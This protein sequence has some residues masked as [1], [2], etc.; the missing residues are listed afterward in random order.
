MWQLPCPFMAYLLES[1]PQVTQYTKFIDQNTHKS[2]VEVW[3]LFIFNFLL[4]FYCFFFLVQ[5][6]SGN[7]NLGKPTLAM[8][9]RTI[10]SF[11]IK[12]SKISTIIYFNF[13]FSIS[14][15]HLYMC[16]FGIYLLRHLN[17]RWSLV[18]NLSLFASKLQRS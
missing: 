12:F 9:V 7:L 8:H 17:M 1:W 13:S 11:E 18:W 14:L 4:L 15:S 10:F 16:A 5:C 6:H 3:T 2:Q